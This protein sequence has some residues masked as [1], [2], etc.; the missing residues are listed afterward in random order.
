M[1][2]DLVQSF[3][4]FAQVA[5]SI[6]LEATPF[7]LLGSLA[8]GFFEVFVPSQAILRV[9]PRRSLPGV[10]VGLVLGMALPCCECGVVPLIR[11][12]LAKGVPVSTAMTYMLAGPVI[13]PIVMASTYVAF[14]GDWSVVW[15]RVGFVAVVAAA[16]GLWFKDVP[17]DELLLAS[18]AMP[19]QGLKPF[20]TVTDAASLS[21]LTPDLKT[22]VLHALDHARSDF[23]SMGAV[24][25][26]G[27]L[28]ASAFKTFAPVELMGLVEKDLF[29][30]VP[31]MMGLAVALSLCSQADAFVAAS[32]TGF[33]LPAKLAFLVLGPILD[34]KLVVMWGQSFRP[35]VVRTLILVPLALV[36]GLCMTFGILTL[37]VPS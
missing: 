34:F 22:R 3:S 32:F 12:F 14:Q 24:L 36:F 16:V 17:G 29:L 33:M 2:G 4:F 31:A 13:N 35:R 25:V 21:A 27:A 30:S 9:L 18:K 5:V 23:L 20:A 1:N 37:G 8:S 15:L 26:L 28:V 6:L 11:R 19:P 10:A 7:L